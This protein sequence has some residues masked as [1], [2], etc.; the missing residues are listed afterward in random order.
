MASTRQ[1]DARLKTGLELKR[2][3]FEGEFGK[4]PL[5]AV[6]YALY[7]LQRDVDADQAIG[8]LR[9]LVPG[10]LTRREDLMALASAIAAKRQAN[11]PGEAEAARV[12]VARIR[13]ER[14]G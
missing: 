9:E 5:R 3:E 11:A 4:S 12:L 1:N 10:Y 8:E 14:L 13:N 6:L 2:A 7:Q